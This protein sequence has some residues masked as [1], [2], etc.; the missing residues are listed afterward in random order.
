M[1]SLGH[2]RRRHHKRWLQFPV[3]TTGDTRT[4]LSGVFLRRL[5]G[6][7]RCY[8][9]GPNYQCINSPCVPPADV[10]DR[11]SPGTSHQSWPYIKRRSIAG[12]TVRRGLQF[13]FL[14]IIDFDRRGL[15]VELMSS[16]LRVQPMNISQDQSVHYSKIQTFEFPLELFVRMKSFP[17][18]ESFKTLCRP[19]S[20]L[21]DQLTW[22][23][24]VSIECT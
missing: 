14:K 7:L 15:A 19:C 24:V 13:R 21:T 5:S 22:K 20:G 16:V 11:V 17:C 4:I 10:A 2:C 1:P 8:R 12:D 3:D 18:A 9:P 6:I 23:S